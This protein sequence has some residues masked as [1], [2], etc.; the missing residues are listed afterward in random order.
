MFAFLEKALA[1]LPIGYIFFGIIFIRNAK[2]EVFVLPQI[3][4]IH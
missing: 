3:V 1:S 2:I 4:Q